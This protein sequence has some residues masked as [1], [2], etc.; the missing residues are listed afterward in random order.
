MV[1]CSL[2]SP[3]VKTRLRFSEEHGSFLS[4]AQLTFWN[5]MF[6]PDSGKQR[7]E[8]LIMTCGDSALKAHEIS[9][10]RILI[11]Q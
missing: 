4:K 2:R 11:R 3:E 1:I 10:F 8:L 6:K 5:S 7:H 9:E